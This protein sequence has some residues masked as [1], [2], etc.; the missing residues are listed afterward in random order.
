MSWLYPL[1]ERADRRPRQSSTEKPLHT[2][3]PT[4]FLP[5]VHT[6]FNHFTASRLRDCMMLML[7]FGR[8]AIYPS[9]LSSTHLLIH[10]SKIRVIFDKKL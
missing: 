9:I 2:K 10:T 8:N 6:G 3:S 1:P 4:A 7:A 5:A